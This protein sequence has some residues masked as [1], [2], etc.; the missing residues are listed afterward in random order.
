MQTI[1]YGI[2]GCG[3]MGQEHIQNIDLLPGAQVGGIYEPDTDMAR[4]ASEMAPNAIMHVDFDTLVLDPNLDCLLIASPNFR[5]AEQ[6]SYI[7]ENR[8]LPL[9]VEKPLFTDPADATGLN[10]LA[11]GYSAPI[12]VAMEYRYMPPIAAL[13][14]QADDVTGGI[15]MLTIREHRFPFLEK[16][17]DW[18]RFNAFS[19]GTFVEKCCHFFDLMRLILK[20]EPVRI[21]ASAGQANNH[22]GESYFGSVPDVWDH[23]Y[24]TVDFAKGARAM[25]ELSMFAEGSEYQ[26]EIS[27]IGPNGKIE[28]YVPGPGRFWPQDLGPAPEPKLVKSPRQPKRPV[29]ETVPVPTDLLEAGDHN[30]STYY[31]HQKFLAL[32]RGEQEAPDVNFD[33]GWRAVA[34]GMAAQASAETGQAVNF[35]AFLADFQ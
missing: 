15:Q 30:G 2:I 9:L 23:G 34:M 33:D 19:G 6:L 25:L 32:L 14:D 4:I 3:M 12:W 16:V 10:A 29:T 24:V 21:Y 35:N 13:L 8:Q 22:L 31:Q 20:D 26:E 11:N 17:G 28:C 5:H 27:A 7:A 1:S 18:N